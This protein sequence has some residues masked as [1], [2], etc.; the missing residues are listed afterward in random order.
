MRDSCDTSVCCGQPNSGVDQEPIDYV[1]GRSLRKGNDK[2]KILGQ[3]VGDSEH[4]R[5]F[6]PESK[7][8]NVA[9][10]PVYST[11][12]TISH[13]FH[14]HTSIS[15]WL[16][17]VTTCGIGPGDLIPSSPDRVTISNVLRSHGHLLHMTY[18]Y[19]M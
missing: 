3:T 10:T 15:S 8:T 16:R 11:V 2:L 13:I 12:R 14:H 9:T 19:H 4:D 5:T 7:W 18:S 1:T 6:N 17:N